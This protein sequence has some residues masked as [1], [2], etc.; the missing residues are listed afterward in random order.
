M[1]AGFNLNTFL[2]Y[3]RR[4]KVIR[5]N[6]LQHKN[7]SFKCMLIIILQHKGYLGVHFKHISL[8]QVRLRCG[9]WLYMYMGIEQVAFIAEYCSINMQEVANAL[10]QGK[11]HV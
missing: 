3:S 10:F 4:Q 8:E 1:R 5:L 2:P 7:A 11:Q 9:R 6:P